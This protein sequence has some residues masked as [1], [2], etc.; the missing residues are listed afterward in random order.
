MTAPSVP[1]AVWLIAAFD[2]VL[3]AVAVW[4]G[5]HADQAGKLVVAVLA[6]IVASVLVGWFLAVI[7]VPWIAPAGGDH[8]TL[9]PV[10]F[11]AAII[12]SGLAFLLARKRRAR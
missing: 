8:A 12:W 6:A 4:F 1:L 7:G 5:W 10:R 11:G 9:L 3:I 2:P